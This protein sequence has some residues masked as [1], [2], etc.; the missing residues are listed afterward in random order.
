MWEGGNHD[1][2]EEGNFPYRPLGSSDEEQ[3]GILLWEAESVNQ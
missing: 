1:K 2:G 3:T